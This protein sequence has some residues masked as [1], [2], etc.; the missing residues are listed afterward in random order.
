MR[1]AASERLKQPLGAGVSLA[2][3]LE[4][5]LRVSVTLR[6]HGLVLGARALLRRT[7]AQN[8]VPSSRV[9]HRR[10]RTRPSRVFHIANCFETA[11][12]VHRDFPYFPSFFKGSGSRSAS[13]RRLNPPPRYESRAR[14]NLLNSH[15]CPSPHFPARVNTTVYAA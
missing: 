13:G 11:T 7:N 12:P 15:G 4:A 5:V 10:D 1:S 14:E 3:R 2:G 6:V 8:L 9:E